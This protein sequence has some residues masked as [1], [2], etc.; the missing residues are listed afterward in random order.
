MVRILLA[1]EEGVKK[2]WNLLKGK[3]CLSG[4]NFSEN[5]IYFIKLICQKHES[6]LGISSSI[7]KLIFLCYVANEIRYQQCVVKFA[8]AFSILTI[9]IY[10]FN[11]YKCYFSLYQFWAGVE[12]PNKSDAGYYSSLKIIIIYGIGMFSPN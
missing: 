7:Y 4:N 3:L 9:Y 11:K 10:I 6:K 8:T 2:R 1:L 12:L 5:S